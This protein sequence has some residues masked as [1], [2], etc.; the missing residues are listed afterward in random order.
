MFTF[1]RSKPAAPVAA[2]VDISTL[3][4][5]NA[6][7]VDQLQAAAAAYVGAYLERAEANDARVLELAARNGS[8]VLSIRIA[9]TPAVT[10]TADPGRALRV[11]I[12]TPTN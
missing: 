10:I 4:G 7:S 1:S 2:P 5:E 9:P 12:A 3:T 11:E 8:I 6:P